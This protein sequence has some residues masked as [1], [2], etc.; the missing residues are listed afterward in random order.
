M[1]KVP[2][3]KRVLGKGLSALLPQRPP[4]EASVPSP[5][6][7]PGASAGP[8]VLPIDRIDPNPLQPRSIFQADRLRELAQSIE[9]NG[10]IQPLI[11]RQ[12]GERYELV[13]GERRW[14]A[15]RLAGLTHVPV[16]IQN[17]A[18]ERVLEL[19]LIENLQ[20]EDLN[21]IEV[22]QALD[23]LHREHY[24]SH[25]EIARRTGKDRTTVT[26]MLRL[27]KLPP[28]VQLL[29]AEN[30]I[31]MGHARALL[32]LQNE[33]HQRLLAEKAAAQGLSV[34]QV[35][36]LV[37][38]MTSDRAESEPPKPQDPNVKAAVAELERV[39]GT[40]VR[41]IEKSPKRGRIEIDYFSL[42]E[43]DRIYNYL[44]EPRK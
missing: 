25:E 4:F 35:E 28:D 15:A 26:N 10:I 21:P 18:P 33:E 2:D 14:R 13:A 41:I 43:L 27:L 1:S 36:R 44:I 7:Q 20:R 22:A 24:L 16:V 17:T 3:S 12:V 37:R 29:L 39:L 11:V 38:Q 8:V 5:P 30:R 42:E 23:R 9:S 34:R 6:A 32:S 40:R 31:S 19:S